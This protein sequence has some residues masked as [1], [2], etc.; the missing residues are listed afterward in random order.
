[1]ISASPLEMQD[2]V[3]PVERFSS[4]QVLDL[5]QPDGS[6]KNQAGD[7]LG[8]VSGNFLLFLAPGMLGK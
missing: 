2:R 8:D 1:M 3:R 6:R 5:R 4:R 7:I